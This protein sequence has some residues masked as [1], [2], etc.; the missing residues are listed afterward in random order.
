MRPSHAIIATGH[1][2]CGE[3]ATIDCSLYFETGL[4]VLLHKRSAR[5][6]QS[7]RTNN[8]S[9]GLLN[10]LGRLARRPKVLMAPCKA[11]LVW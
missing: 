1:R 9:L 5:G 7:I 3:D 4:N 2:K 6:A 11:P 10:L 8:P